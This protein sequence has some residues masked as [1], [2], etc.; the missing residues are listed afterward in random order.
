MWQHGR[1]MAIPSVPVR[2]SWSGLDSSDGHLTQGDCK[3]WTNVQVPIGRPWAVTELVKDY[4]ARARGRAEPRSAEPSTCGGFSKKE[5]SHP[6]PLTLGR[7]V[8]QQ[9]V[10]GRM[11]GREESQ[12]L[13]GEG[14]GCELGSLSTSETLS[15]V[16][17][18]DMKDVLL[19]T[20][21]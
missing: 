8:T 2:S 5:R 6:K 3:S 20:F 12:L 17:V 7:L 15:Y 16:Y 13:L 4:L 11:H 21:L 19:F 9:Q 1:A 18:L 10:T 14:G